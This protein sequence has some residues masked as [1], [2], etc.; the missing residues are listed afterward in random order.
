MARRL[1][2]SLVAIG[3]MIAP[4]AAQ[5]GSGLD[6]TIINR[7]DGTTTTVTT[8]NGT[9]SWTNSDRHGGGQSGRDHDEIVNDI[10][11]S[12]ETGGSSCDKGLQHLI[13]CSK[14]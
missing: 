10:V 3:V 4:L 6:V 8:E 9:T 7:P 5:Q 11:K 13:S 14:L 1:L 12:I 2:M